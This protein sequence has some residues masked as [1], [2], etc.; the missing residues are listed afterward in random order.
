M[1]AFK[2]TSDSLPFSVSLDYQIRHKILSGKLPFKTKFPLIK[3]L[4]AQTGYSERAIKDAYKRLSSEGHISTAKK[5]GS[6][7]SYK[8]DNTI[9]SCYNKNYI[10][11]QNIIQ[12]M[13][14]QGFSNDDIFSCFYNAFYESKN[15][16]TDIVF[17][18]ENI[19]DLIQ[20]KD[21]LESKLNLPVQALPIDFFEKR[22][23]TFKDKIIVTTFKNFLKIKS[24]ADS[25]NIF[26]LKI[27]PSLEEF[28]NFNEVPSNANIFYITTSNE[29]KKFISETYKYIQN[30]FKNFHIITYDEFTDFNEKPYMIIG[31]SQIFKIIKTDEDIIKIILE[32]FYDNEGITFIKEKIG[33]SVEW[34]NV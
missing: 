6:Y 24:F 25:L 31:T 33:K 21:E 10:Y 30:N 3:E 1:F 27:T 23:N 17:V 2:K 18:E 32:R 4:S 28:I 15:I 22:H 9:T 26:P 12:N 7:V 8:G 13:L 20:G 14:L 34:V 29:N 19:F 16:K 11:F 5:G